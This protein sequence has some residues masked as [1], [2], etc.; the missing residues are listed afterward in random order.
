MNRPSIKPQRTAGQAG[1]VRRHAKFLLLITLFAP[2]MPSTAPAGEL[3]ERFLAQAPQIIKHF[4]QRNCRNVGVLKFRIK[5]GN[6]PVSD[7]V[8]TLNSFLADRL[9]VA[10]VLANDNDTSTQ[11]GIIR[12]ASA[13]AASIAGAD[14]TSAQGRE[15]LLSGRYPLAWGDSEQRI[16]ADAF[17]TGIV[18]VSPDLRDMTIG[19]LAFDRTEDALNRIVPVFEAAVDTDTLAELGESFMLRGAFD[20]GRIEL[21]KSEKAEAAVKEAVKEAVKTKTGAKSHP[22]QDSSAPVRLGVFYDDREVSLDFQNGEAQIPEPRE[23]QKIHLVLSRTPKAEG[24]LAV[25]LKV[26]GENTLFRERKRDIDCRK[27]ILEPGAPPITVRGYQKSDNEVEAFRILSDADS[28]SRA[29]DYGTDVGMITIVVFKEKES[30][31]ELPEGLPD[32]TAEDLLA[33][34]RGVFPTKTPANLAVLKRQLR[35]AGEETQTRGLIAEGEQIAG[36]IRTVTF[37]PDPV[38]VLAAAI[39]YYQP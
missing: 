34:T 24:R 39:R 36:R 37:N 4:Q 5:K 10:L 20:S 18:Q 29:I 27:W 6:D 14:H 26:N 2:L 33:L 7:S 25:V 15:K 17:V 3:E 31:D 21:A 11:L 19:I 30:G 32:D 28:Q 38:V 35:E 23:G 1:L 22:L 16:E 13:V 8:G 9:E 12:N